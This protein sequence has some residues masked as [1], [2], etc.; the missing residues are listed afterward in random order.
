M[1]CTIGSSVHS[2]VY[3]VQRALANAENAEK[4]ENRE[5]M[6]KGRPL[7]ETSDVSVNQWFFDK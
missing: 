6:A 3:S 5:K 2:A 1:H 7:M 4:R